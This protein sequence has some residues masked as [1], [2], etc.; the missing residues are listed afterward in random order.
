LA[1]V[2][3]SDINSGGGSVFKGLPWPGIAGCIERCSPHRVPEC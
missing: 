3:S 2:P 1:K